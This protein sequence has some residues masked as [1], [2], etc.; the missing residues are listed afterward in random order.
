MQ[1]TEDPI[2]KHPH[3]RHYPIKA[4]LPVAT[5]GGIYL[6]VSAIALSLA[7]RTGGQA[8]RILSVVMGVLSVGYC[9][10]YGAKYGGVH[11]RVLT[12]GIAI[13]NHGRTRVYEWSEIASAQYDFSAM[14]VIIFLKSGQEIRLEKYD[15]LKEVILAMDERQIRIDYKKLEA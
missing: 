7:F 10:Y 1:Q 2:I 8:D 12:R 3:R 4:I 13:A 6:L 14:S 5:Q 15:D 11:Y 9:A